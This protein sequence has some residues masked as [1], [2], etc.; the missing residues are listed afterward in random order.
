MSDRTEGGAPPEA[1]GSGE[2]E[3][4]VEVLRAFLGEDFA[5]VLRGAVLAKA[6][7]LT[8]QALKFQVR[9]GTC[10]L[11]SARPEGRKGCAAHVEEVAAYLASL[12]RPAGGPR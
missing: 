5:P 11:R 3:R 2:V 9:R 4:E 6:L 1:G 12:R 10:P 7:G 8:H